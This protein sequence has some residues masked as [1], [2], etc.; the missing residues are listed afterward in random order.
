MFGGKLFRGSV[1]PASAAPVISTNAL[2]FIM[3]NHC[4][5]KKQKSNQMYQ[6]YS[7]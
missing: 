3:P 5:M 4:P 2:S 6:Q 7:K 1:L